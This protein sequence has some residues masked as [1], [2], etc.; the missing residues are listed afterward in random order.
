MAPKK[1]DRGFSLIELA[2]AITIIGLI[3]AAAFKGGPYLI[4][5]SKV[6]SS[7][8]LINDLSDATR[9]FKSQYHYLPGDMPSATTRI[10]SSTGNGN[11]DGDVDLDERML[12]AE[13][14]HLVGQIKRAGNTSTN[15]PFESPF[16][17]A[18]IISAALARGNSSP[19]TGSPTSSTSVPVNTTS[20]QPYTRNVALLEALPGEAAFAIDNKLDDGNYN[21]GSIRGSADYS[22]TIVSCLAVAL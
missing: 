13:H 22:S 3:F 6:S 18:W 12:V 20:P 21:S 11:G 15:A 5:S 7:I 1:A 17:R 4:M 9:L 10:N 16:G 14:L 19:C 8:S 2:I